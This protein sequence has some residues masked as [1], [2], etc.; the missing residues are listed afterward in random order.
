MGPR[1]ELSFEVGR[2][3]RPY[4]VLT[5]YLDQGGDDVVANVDGADAHLEALLRVVVDRVDPAEADLVEV[6]GGLGVDRLGPLLELLLELRAIE[7]SN[8]QLAKALHDCQEE[9]G[10]R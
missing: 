6:V 7:P 9:V 5:S 2:R 1:R 3:R 8:L 10:Y 4:L